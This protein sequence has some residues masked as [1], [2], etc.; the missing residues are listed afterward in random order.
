MAARPVG[1]V[2]K[3][4]LL[5]KIER[6]DQLVTIQDYLGEIIRSDWSVARP[7]RLAS[8]EESCR[9]LIG[10][11]LSIVREGRRGHWTN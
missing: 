3:P 6:N 1:T 4:P 8:Y 11:C 7:S 10:I 5:D 2:D 9:R